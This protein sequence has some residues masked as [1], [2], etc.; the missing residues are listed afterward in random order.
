MASVSS[1]PSQVKDST[2]QSMNLAAFF[3]RFQR[4]KYVFSGTNTPSVEYDRLCSVLQWGKR[5]ADRHRAELIQIINAKQAEDIA[6]LSLEIL[7]NK[8]NAAGVQIHQ[9]DAV[10]ISKAIATEVNTLQITVGNDKVKLADLTKLIE[11]KFDRI[12]AAEIEKTNQA[13]LLRGF[14][15]K[16]EFHA[17]KY[18]QAAIPTEE[19]SRL[20][21]ARKWGPA[22]ISSAKR[23]FDGIMAAPSQHKTSGT[24]EP[25]TSQR[26]NNEHNI[27][28]ETLQN[29]KNT[30]NIAAQQPR[31]LGQKRKSTPP[32]QSSRPDLSKS[33]LAEFFTRFNCSN[34]TY[35]GLSATVEFDRLTNQEYYEL[36]RQFYQTVEA[37][38]DWFVDI[39]CKRTGL[40]KEEY[41]AIFFGLGQAPMDVDTATKLLRSIN[42]NIYDF[43]DYHYELFGLEEKITP[44]TDN[45]KASREPTATLDPI[46]NNALRTLPQMPTKFPSVVLLGIYCKVTGR[47]YDL[48]EARSNGTLV[49]LLKRVG[50]HFHRDER[51]KFLA[52]VNQLNYLND[53]N[54][55]MII[56]IEDFYIGKEALANLQSDDYWE[57]VEN[58]ELYSV[59]FE[60]V[61][62]RGVEN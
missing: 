4:G 37:Q 44:G 16:F 50:K 33:P 49:L 14:F 51:D 27:N 58:L 31:Q 22:R 36:K 42:I 47:I 30:P 62:V 2:Q 13:E 26:S 12:I 56:C 9:N 23:E 40:K 43:L 60:R 19:F 11:A 20:C 38:F 5:K 17:Y 15:T 3:M 45:A 24:T 32:R 10:G 39:Q 7:I 8:F 55:M 52:E 46:T 61:H 28:I 59:L 57:A 48:K 21:A 54:A 1:A 25:S 6:M 34:Y 29:T 41:V 53:F 18:N 35:K